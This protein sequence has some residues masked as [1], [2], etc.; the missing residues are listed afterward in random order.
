MAKVERS[1]LIQYSAEQMFALVNDIEAYPQYMSGCTAAE[2][3]YQDEERVEAR[4]TLEKAGMRQSFVTRN[5][6][7]PPTSM[8]ME[9]LEGPF[10][11]FDGCW[12]F[13]VLS[14]DACKVSLSLDFEFNN[15]LLG[16]TVG[17]WFG[18]VANTLVD[19]LLVRAKQ[20][21]G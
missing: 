8:A 16:L 4:L 14:E 5:T 13:Q 17:R 20:V 21:Y 6:L 2:V 9:L 12:T 19:S 11:N 7:T 3:L 10:S 18:G 15:K 1:A